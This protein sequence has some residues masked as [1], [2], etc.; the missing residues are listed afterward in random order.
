MIDKLQQCPY[1]HQTSHHTIKTTRSF[2]CKASKKGVTLKRRRHRIQ[3]P[4]SESSFSPSRINPII[5]EQCFQQGNVV[6]NIIIARNNHT[7]LSPQSS[8]AGA[9]TT[10][11][12]SHVLSP[13]LFRYP[14]SYNRTTAT[15]V[16]IYHADTYSLQRT[17]HL[18]FNA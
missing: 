12:I 6:K 18:L 17:R 4:S 15:A 11:Q 16:W 10:I 2:Y 5:F 14:G 8:R 13:S 3:P 1:S 9:R 7:G